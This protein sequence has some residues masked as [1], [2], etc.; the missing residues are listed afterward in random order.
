MSFRLSHI[1]DYHRFIAVDLGLYRVRAGIYDLS[2]GE[3]ECIGFSSARQSRKNFVDG[4]IADIRWVS[5]AIQQAILQAW[6]KL[7]TI[8]E[9]IIINFP[10]HR[11]VFDSISTQYVR[12]DQSSTLTMQEIDSMIKMTEKDSFERAR[13]KSQKQF[14]VSNDDLRLISSTIVSVMIDGKKVTNPIG[15][16]GGRIRLTVLN[17]FVPSSEFNIIRSVVAALGKRA[18]SII[19]SPLVF[20]KFI[21]DTAYATENAC[22]IDIGQQHTTVIV[23]RHNEILGFEVFRYGTEDLM[24]Y[25]HES[26]TH[27]SVLQLENTICSEK[28]MKEPT[29]V[30]DLED[31]LAYL[32][33]MILGY[34]SNEHIDV[35]LEHI[36]LHGSIFENPYIGEQ[37]S[38]LIHR[39]LGIQL[40]IDRLSAVANKPLHH[41]QVMTHWLSLMAQ[42]LLLVKKDPLVR[43]L[44]YVLYQYE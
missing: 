44:R 18:I 25:I 7:E 29:Y 41:D 36:F 39:V 40:P 16:T 3:L 12:A 1:H 9:D 6:Q 4:D 2:G 21:E 5:Q 42:E 30:S 43:I 13:Y 27:L 20:P 14:G 8:P 19:P 35:R 10:S 38:Q 22:Y 15:F 28:K 33:D 23:T 24:N 34:L 31:F 32:G 11:F 37:F 26:H 17:V